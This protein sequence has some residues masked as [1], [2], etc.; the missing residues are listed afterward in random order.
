L[1]ESKRSPKKGFKG[2][3][4][5]LKK[6][7]GQGLSPSGGSKP[8]DGEENRAA[9]N[10]EV[11]KP[12]KIRGTQKKKRKSW[13][14]QRNKKGDEIKPKGDRKRL[15]GFGGVTSREHFQDGRGVHL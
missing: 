10:R 7:T 13:G 1:K 11:E 3:F 15:M 2:G 9:E 4:P 8:C 14:N 12:K 5:A 6:L